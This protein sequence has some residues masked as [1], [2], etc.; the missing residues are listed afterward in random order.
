M[1]DKTGVIDSTVKNSKH[2]CGFAAIVGLPNAG[3]STLM[4]RFICEK[5]SIV[6]PKP[7]TTRSNVTCIL[8]TEN[9]Q[10]IFIDTPGILKPRYRMQEVMVSYITAAVEESDI[11]LVI[12]DAAAFRGSFLPELIQ[13]AERVDA[14]R[15]VVALNKIDLMKKPDLLPIIKKTSGLFPGCEI[16]PISALNGDGVD[17]L[18]IAILSRL[19]ESP[20]LYPEDVI[21]HEPERFFVSELIREAVFLSMKQEIPYASAVVIDRFEE[22]K[23]KVVIH[24]SILVEKKSQKAIIIGKDGSTIREIGIKS[25]LGIEAFLGRDV[26]LDLHVKIRDN[27]RNK[28]TC[29]REIGLIRR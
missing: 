10:I 24:A 7:Q 13:F 27:W 18:L 26:F 9:Y 23:P 11:C 6:S 21:S 19:P 28:D 14:S 22:K 17:E 12:I 8:T 25:R 29:L 16:I 15:V 20:S 2:I 4:N 3:K 5:V 1:R